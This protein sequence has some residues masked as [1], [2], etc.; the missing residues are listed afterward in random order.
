[1]LG[2]LKDVL[3]SI[4]FFGL[5]ETDQLF[6]ITTTDKRGCLGKGTMVP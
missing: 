2:Q 3:R 5:L 6:S 4:Y 1:M